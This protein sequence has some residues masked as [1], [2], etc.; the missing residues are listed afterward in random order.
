MK[1]KGIYEIQCISDH[2]ANTKEF[3]R[4]AKDKIQK[5]S[6]AVAGN[7]YAELCDIEITV[8]RLKN[9]VDK[10]LD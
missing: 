5:Q 8:N 2:L 7:T 3:V 6:V 4:K 10:L 9:R 1:V